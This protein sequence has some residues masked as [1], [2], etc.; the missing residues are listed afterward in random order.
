MANFKHFVITTRQVVASNE[1]TNTFNYKYEKQFT[2]SDH[3]E[4]FL[5]FGRYQVK[6]NINKEILFYDP[7]FFNHVINNKDEDIHFQGLTNDKLID[8]N[9]IETGAGSEQFFDALFDE[10]NTSKKDLLIFLFGFHN[11]IKKELRHMDLLHKTYCTHTSPIGSVLMISWPSQGLIGYAEEMGSDIE[12]TGRALS[13]FFLKLSNAIEKRRLQKQY[14]PRINFMPQSMGHRIV[15]SMMTL[16]KKQNDSIYSKVNELFHRLILMSPDIE[17]HALS[18]K[19]EGSYKFISEL[20]KR[21]YL[22]Y[23]NQ[24]PILKMNLKHVKNKKRLGLTGPTGDINNIR[25]C[26]VIQYGQP[27]VFDLGDNQRH[28]FFEFDLGFVEFLQKI[29]SG[30]DEELENSFNYIVKW[31][32]FY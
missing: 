18:N 30:Q 23:S 28:R 14:I 20:G 31:N 22:F 8:E 21:T 25:V 6:Q 16:L 29:F 12:T 26:N 7:L 17:D 24:D 32:D 9:R 5:R 19:S 15:E 27:P 1:N 2:S 4:S 10:L 11:K 13:V 3:A